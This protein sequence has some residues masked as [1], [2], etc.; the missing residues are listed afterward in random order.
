MILHRRAIRV[1]EVHAFCMVCSK[2][3]VLVAPFV[4]DEFDFTQAIKKIPTV[5]P[6]HADWF[7]G[8][9]FMFYDQWEE[10]QNATHKQ[11]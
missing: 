1:V 9:P 5:C 3:I 8:T 6:D 4:P 7:D 10:Y 11:T 2:R